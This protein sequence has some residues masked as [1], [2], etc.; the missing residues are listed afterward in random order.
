MKDTNRPFKIDSIRLE[1]ILN[2]NPNAIYSQTRTLELDQK[3]QLELTGWLDSINFTHFC[4]FTTSKPIS[5]YS[6]RRI[7]EK[8]YNVCLGG[9]K[10]S[11]MF[12]A[13][14]KFEVRDGFHFHALLRT[15]LQPQQ[16]WEWY[17]SRYGRC[18]IIDNSDPERMLTASRYVSKY[19][20]K[21]LTDYDIYINPDHLNI[22]NKY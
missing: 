10:V 1:S 18:Q 4:T 6:T 13:S 12:W 14:E 16:I 22:N 3:R 20:T 5:I 2:K 11:S 17:Y 9:N 19:I 7:A 15:P 8:L 21:E